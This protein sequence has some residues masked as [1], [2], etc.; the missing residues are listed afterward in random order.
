MALCLAGC[1]ARA[2][3]RTANASAA[4][5]PQPLSIP[6]TQVALPKPQPVDPD[7]LAAGPPAAPVETPPAPRPPRSQPAPARPPIQE[8]VPA[9][10]QK[11]LQE[12]AQTRK[13]EIR[14]LLDQ[15]QARRLNGDERNLVSRI[16][17]FV[18][19]SDDAEKRGDMRE[20]DALAE[21]A[22]ILSREL[23]SGK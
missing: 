11:R 10:E 7:A 5:A 21:R 9:A 15:A 2:K 13:R 16:Q 12:S 19:L 3:P 18:K 20:A 14:R 4:T 6:Q 17:S 1:A 23:Q 8:I 22:Q